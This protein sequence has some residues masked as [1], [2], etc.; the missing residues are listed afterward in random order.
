[1]EIIEKRLYFALETELRASPDK[2][3]RKILKLDDHYVLKTGHKLMPP[4]I[5]SI[6][7]HCAEAHRRLREFPSVVYLTN[8]RLVPNGF[9]F[10]KYSACQKSCNTSYDLHQGI[11]RAS[12]APVNNV[13]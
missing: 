8:D 11:A 5:K 13:V 2:F 12:S 1:M 10:K 6:I 3:P 7:R 4:S 9:L